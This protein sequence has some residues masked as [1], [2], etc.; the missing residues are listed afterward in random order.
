MKGI[1]REFSVTRTPQQNGI[2]ERKNMTLIEAA[3]TMLA[4][5]LL[6][7]PFWAEAVNTACYVQNRVLV[8]K[9]HNK[10]PYELLLGRT[11]SIG[12]MRP[13]I[14]PVTI[15]NTLDP[16]G[17]FDGKDDEGFLV[18][19][20]LF[21]IDTLTKSMNYQPVTLGNLPNPSA[22][23]QEYFDA[24]KAGEENVQQ[25]VLFPLWSSGSKDPQNTNDDTTFDVKEPECEVEKPES[26]V[27]VSPSSSAKTKKH[28]DKTTKEAKG[29]SPDDTPV[30]AV[31]QIST[32][33]TNT[34]SDAGPSNTT[35]SLTLEKSSYVDPSQYPDDQNMLALEDITYSDDEEDVGAEADFTNLE[36]TITINL[37]PTTRV[38]KD[39]PEEVIDYEE[40][41]A[42]VARI[43]AIR[44][45][46]AYASFMGFMVYQMDVKSTFLYRTIEEEV[47]VCQPLGFE[48]PDYPDKIYKVVKALYGL[49]QAPR[50]WYE[51]LANYLL[52]NGFQR[53]KIDQTLFIK[54]QKGDI[55][56]VQVYVYDI[57]FGSTNKDLCKAFEKLMKDKFQ[58]SSMGELT[59]FLASTPIDIEKPLLKDPD[60][61]D[62]DVHIYRFTFNLV[63][64]LD[65]D[66]AGASLDRKS[67]TGG[68]QFL[69]C[70]LISWQ[71][72]K[73][74][75][76]ATSSTEADP[77]QTISSK[78]SSNMLMA[79]NLPKIVW[80]LT[81]HVAL[82]KSWLV[83]KQTALGQTTTDASEGF[84]QILNFLDASSIQKKVIITEDTVHQ[85]LRLDDAESIDCLPNEDIFTELARMGYE[86]PSTKLTFSKA[87]FLAQWKF[88]IHTITILMSDAS[89]AVT[90]T[91]V[92][93]DSEPWRYYR[94]D[95][96][97]TGP[98]RVI[99]YGYD[100]LLIHP[101]APPSPDYVPGPE[102]P[103]SLD[104]VPGPEHPPSPVEIP[105]VP[106]PEYP[107]YLAPSDDEAPLEDQPLPADASSITASP[108]YV[109]SD[110]D[111][112][113][114]E[115][116]EE[117][118]FEDEEDDE[119][120]LAS[121]DSS[122][123]PIVDPVLPAGDTEALEADE[124]THAPGSPI[125]IPFSQTRLRMAQKT[126]RPEPPMS[127]SME[128]CIPRH[129]ALPSPPLLV[130]SL[131]IPFPSPLTTSPTDTGTPLAY[132]TVWIRMRALLPSTS[133]RTDIPEADM[134]PRKRACLTTPAPEFEIRKSSTAGAVRQPGPTGSDLRRYRVEQAG[135][136]ITDTW[137]EIVDTDR[138]DH[139]R[140]AML[141]DREAM[142]AREAWTSSLQTQLTTTL[143][144]IKI[145]EAKDPEPQEGPAKADISWNF[146]YLLAIIKMAP[147]K[148]TT[149]ATPATTTT[150]TTTITNAQLQALT[151][152]DVI[153]ALVERDVDKSRNGDNNNDSGTGG[154]RQMTT[155]R[156]CTYIDF[157][158]CQPMSFQGTERVVGLTRWGIT[159]FE[160]GVQGHYKSDC[161]KPKNGNQG[162]RAGNGNVVAIAYAVGTAR[163]NPNSNVVTGTHFLNYR[164]AL[165]LFDTSADR[166]F[167]S[168]AFS[169]L[170]DIIPTTL[171]HGYDVELANEM[172]SF[173]VIIGTDWLVKYHAV[174]VCDKKLLCVPFG[175]EILIF[176]G[177][178]SNNG[179]KTRLNIISCTKTQ[180]YLLKGCPIFL[181]HVTTKETEDQS[182]KKRLEDV[183]IFQD[184]PEKEV[185]T[186]L[187]TAMFQSKVF[188]AVLMQRKKVIAYGSRQ[189]KVHEKNYTTHD[190]KL[191]AVVF[192]LTIWKHNLYGTK[193]IVFTEH[194]SLQHILDQKELN[195]RQRRWLELLSDYHCEIRYHPE[196]ENVVAD[197]LS[198]K[199]RIK[200][201]RVRALVMIIGLDL[202]RKI[203]KAQTEA[204][205]LENL[206]SEDVGVDRL[207]KSAHFLP[208][209][210]INP[211]DKLARLYLKEVVTRHKIPISIICDPDPRFTSN[212]W[213]AFQKAMGTRLNMSMTYHPETDGQSERT[214]QTLEDM[215]RACVIDFG[216]GWERHLPLVEFSYN[217]SYH[218]SIKAA[219]FEVLYGRKCRSP[220]CLA[221][222]GDA[223][224]TGP[225]L[226]H[227]ITEKIVQIKQRIQ[228]AQDRQKSYADV[229]FKPFKVLAKVGT[230]AYILKLPEQ[231]SRVHSTFYV[232]NLKKCLS[233]E[234]LAI[235]LDEI[236][237]DDKLYFVK[238][239][240]EVI[241]R[242]VKRLKQSRIPIIKVRWNSR[243]GLEFTWERE[244]QFRKKYP[245]LFTTNA[246][247]S[248][249]AS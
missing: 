33:N 171:D 111:A 54:K 172:G 63:A 204:M 226:I 142:Y 25:Y 103:P 223:Q 235:S 216:N 1:K 69:G 68:C 26:E 249:A 116:P 146:S 75:V 83:Q 51:T 164:Y 78:D 60:G 229:N 236:H 16:I 79:D 57:I 241:D 28:D 230:I 138:P 212:F 133:R 240:V 188:S 7:I 35:V 129:A 173:D 67:I 74:T 139:R 41:F 151:D 131:P 242:K 2:A 80:Y 177:D 137:D 121:T 128:A 156:E 135:Y 141:M 76:V 207:T 99:I 112:T 248:S 176:H 166:S 245:Q 233:D 148:R 8:T 203:L 65:C 77:D 167:I 169:S 205:K 109:P 102:H 56:L 4:D 87:F 221:E 143:G 32:N 50:A 157:L 93:T 113:D 3:R 150:L 59:L 118:P 100:G 198:Q 239:P 170:I 19:Y 53:G 189:L 21:D 227:E 127:A 147:M 175:D 92:Y 123:V 120:H 36:T 196:K 91:S 194:K 85:A 180:R 84:D 243:R 6:P 49:H 195:M 31:G 159:C 140:T 214:I 104:Y 11:P 81:Y 97:E 174:I 96:T 153:T 27:Y 191:G 155:P 66:Y 124:P 20:S 9:P 101:V 90:Y 38:H 108:D 39:H 95:S 130:P 244:D 82:M 222:V 106:E 52:E 37:I 200:P 168:T 34:F 247:S 199:E 42:P 94:E 217:N 187:F 220:V 238:E 117:E 15:L 209:K 122:V 62:V 110:D 184:F 181:A 5:L 23:I 234:P 29:K 201:L 185:R 134:P 179:H 158:K 182:K 190:L 88:P 48:D 126:V 225:E 136:G 206:K 45:F 125:I 213:K 218:T 215:L 115:D 160:C 70:R 237:I 86:K 232:S 144:R 47:Y 186:S 163:T 145:L 73:Q 12:F 24:E 72:K 13:F 17:K 98:S 154:R 89:S 165:I 210:K 58:I 162:N 105:Y 43:E 161:P 149:R 114:D 224:L 55:L 152:R 246:P 231:L 71:C 178:G 18:G 192:V 183:P 61:E 197:V 30:P 64:Y 132:R 228:A 10:I 22:V 193:C 14:C 107:K 211:M 202:P 46:L 44:L 208:M 119:E 40:F 219:P